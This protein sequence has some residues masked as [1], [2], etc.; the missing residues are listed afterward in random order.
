[1]DLFDNAVFVI[2]AK[3]R[4]SA[5]QQYCNGIPGQA[6]NDKTV[7]IYGDCHRGIAPFRDDV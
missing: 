5:I 3:A 6:R 4:I 1:M 2:L 7:N